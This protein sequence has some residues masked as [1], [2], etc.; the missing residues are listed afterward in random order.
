[1]SDE[2]L[3]N[4]LATEIGLGKSRRAK[5]EVSD[6]DS[7]DG[8]LPR[9]V[10]IGGVE[11]IIAQRRGYQSKMNECGHDRPIMHEWIIDGRLR[12]FPDGNVGVLVDDKRPIGASLLSSGEDFWTAFPGMA[13]TS[14]GMHM[15]DPIG[16][17]QEHCMYCSLGWCIQ[18]MTD[19]MRVQSDN[20][21]HASCYWKERNRIEVAQ[22][23]ELSLKAGLFWATYKE[24]PNE[25]SKSP[26]YTN[27]IH[28]DTHPA[29]F[30][31]FKFGWRKRVL[32]IE[33]DCRRDKDFQIRFEDLFEDQD[34][35]KYDE[36]AKHVIHAHG[37][38]MAVLY[39]KKIMSEIEKSRV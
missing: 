28:I 21:V 2:N 8:I 6:F 23:V 36:G 4:E 16:S 22:L 26:G 38:D 19:V 27:W 13:T 39:L 18:N 30:M 20:L 33:L 35:T 12:L 3:L 15:R 34:V 17:S 5:N 37:S 7:Y 10:H 9:L 11:N 32:S 14:W 29:Y 1:M 25:Y 31:E 24:I